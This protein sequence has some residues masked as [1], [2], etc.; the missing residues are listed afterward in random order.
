MGYAGRLAGLPK[1]C[2]SCPSCS[3]AAS[4][5]GSIGICGFAAE[6]QRTQMLQDPPIVPPKVRDRLCRLARDPAQPQ[7]RIDPNT[8]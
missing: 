3:G 1:S 5:G 4:A 2:G 8:R 7:L 6:Q